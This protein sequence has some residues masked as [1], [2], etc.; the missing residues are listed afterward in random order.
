MH[1]ATS[2]LRV[3]SQSGKALVTGT[4][5]PGTGHVKGK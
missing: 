2:N 3:Q 1:G 5:G 4:V